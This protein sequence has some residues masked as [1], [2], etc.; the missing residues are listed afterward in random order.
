ME[1]ECREQL[2]IIQTRRG[3]LLD[4]GFDPQLTSATNT[5]AK[6]IAVL[7]AEGRQQD[8]H[9]F[10]AVDDLSPENED[11]LLREFLSEISPKRRQGFQEFLA[12]F[13]DSTTLLGHS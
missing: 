6:S 5:L 3:E 8:K 13:A 7:S 9:K 12:E 11:A 1:K 2:S 10:A 4:G